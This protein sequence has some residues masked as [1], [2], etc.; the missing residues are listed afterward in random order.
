MTTKNSDNLA[1]REK[2]VR[3]GRRRLAIKV[4]VACIAIVL[5]A[6]TGFF[7]HRWI[8]GA[9]ARETFRREASENWDEIQSESEEVAAA[10]EKVTSPSDLNDVADVSSGM[11]GFIEG[12]LRELEGEQVPSDYQDLS[13]KQQTALEDLKAY[14]E[15]IE[16][17][18]ES[19]DEEMVES[20]RGVL[21]NKS[22]RAL[23]SVNEF[24][25]VAS[26]AKG[27]PVAEFYQAGS[28][29]VEA[30][31]PPSYADE[32]E[33]MAV[34]DAATEFIKADI[35]DQDFNKVF[36]MISSRLK[37]GLDYYNIT[38]EDYARDWTRAWGDDRPVDFFVKKRDLSFPEPGRAEVKAIVYMEDGAPR[39]EKMR[40]V[41]EQGI[42]KIDSY[43]FIGWG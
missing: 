1:Q 34:L 40:L 18:S 13:R 31:Q 28:Y 9:R 26:F 19:G 35:E 12:I 11:R 32:A 21:E 39:L 20:G 5:A 42:W 25:A 23:S 14:T 10:L 30:W 22:R 37:T 15:Y 17:L 29:L 2:P 6:G 24:M 41:K 36:S 4:A 27:R 16:E 3:V 38:V 43:P 33:S 7:L 8:A